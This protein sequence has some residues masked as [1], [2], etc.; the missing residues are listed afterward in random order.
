LGG[1]S[2]E[3]AVYSLATDEKGLIYGGT[4]WNSGFFVY[5]PLNGSIVYLGQPIANGGIISSL[6]AKA[7]EIYGSTS[8]GGDSMYVESH[9]FSYN[10]TTGIFMD[11]GRPVAGERASKITL[12][13]DGKIYGGTSPNGYLFTYDPE[14]MV[15]TIIGEPVQGEGIASIITGN[16]GK[17]YISLS[18][19]LYSFDP[20]FSSIDN[21][22]EISNFIPV[23]GEFFWSLTEGMDGN[24]YGGT[25]PSGYLFKYNPSDNSISFIQPLATETRIRALTTGI[26][27]KIYG[28]TGWG[29]YLFSYDSGYDVTPPFITF[30]SP[31]P[32]NN[33]EVNVNHVNVSIV[34]NEPGFMVQL[35]WNGVMENMDGSGT[36]FYMNKTGLANGVYGYY[37]YTSDAAG[38]FNTSEI[39][40]VTVNVTSLPP[41]GGRIS[42]FKINDTNG[43]GIWDQ[44]ETGIA[45]W[46]ISLTDNQG[47]TI[48]NTTDN[49]G[50]Y[51][52]GGLVAGTY[53]VAEIPDGG[54]TQ[55][56]PAGKYTVVLAADQHVTGKNFLNQK[57][58]IP[59]PEFPSL[60]LIIPCVGIFS[61]V[62]VLLRRKE[63]FSS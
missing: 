20:E 28:G 33:S 51:L 3:D 47:K 8:D 12:G 9:L 49:N 52:F 5:D 10:S 30:I 57:S 45:N 14:T 60:G 41:T 21:L 24:I 13:K 11:L 50:N 43:N 31:T 54:W 27:G 62:F 17:I 40:R 46:E 53:T 2:G 55:T 29:A 42:G 39:R 44:G 56:F 37:V 63:K 25:A 18:G 1:V 16:D 19:G 38:N 23:S 35:N 6:A 7:N 34:L 48:T 61:L 59:V 15:F 32:D 22:F 26:D 4:A 36:N 58:E